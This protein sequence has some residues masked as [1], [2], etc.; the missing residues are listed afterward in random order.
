MVGRSGV[1]EVAASRYRFITWVAI[2][3]EK[4]KICDSRGRPHGL[5]ISI[6]IAKRRCDFARKT[7]PPINSLRT[8]EEN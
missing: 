7:G 5:L 6:V 4:V 8:L 1:M 2:A 3:R